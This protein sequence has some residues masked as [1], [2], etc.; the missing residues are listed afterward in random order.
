[1]NY[2]K[3]ELDCKDKELFLVVSQE[4]DKNQAWLKD[5][6]TYSNNIPEREAEILQLKDILN[7]DSVSVNNL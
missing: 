2:L 4:L 5:Q 1:M 3:Q 7:E 6:A